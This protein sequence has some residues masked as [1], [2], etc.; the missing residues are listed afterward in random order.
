LATPAILVVG[1]FLS[2]TLFVDRSGSFRPGSEIFHWIIRVLAAL[3]F[4]L[5]WFNTFTSIR[6]RDFE[7]G[8]L[9]GSLATNSL[10]ILWV[11]ALHQIAGEL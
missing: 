11:V 7:W 8:W 10:L 5:S 2:E 6:T 1:V 4:L 3:T 9:I